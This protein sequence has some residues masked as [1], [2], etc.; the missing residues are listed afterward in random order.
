MSNWHRTRYPAGTAKEYDALDAAVAAGKFEEAARL[1][2][3][4][5]DRHQKNTAKRV[6]A[7]I[8]RKAKQD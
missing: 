5:D 1:R 8:D 6:R 7:S 4:M 2:D 3:E